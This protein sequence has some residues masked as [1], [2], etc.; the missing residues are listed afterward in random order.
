MTTKVIYF[1][2][3]GKEEAAE[4]NSD[5]DADDVRGEYICVSVCLQLCHFA[6]CR[7]PVSWF[8]LNT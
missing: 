3:N 2:V 5:D 1:L 6:V 4:F 8:C 7:L